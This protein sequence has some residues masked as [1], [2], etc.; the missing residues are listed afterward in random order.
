MTTEKQCIDFGLKLESLDRRTNLQDVH[1]GSL[2]VCLAR[3]ETRIV[4][5]EHKQSACTTRV[6]AL[7]AWKNK[8]LGYLGMLGILTMYIIESFRDHFWGGR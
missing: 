1:I 5:L 2:K 4:E 3:A 7:Q 8:A 6:T